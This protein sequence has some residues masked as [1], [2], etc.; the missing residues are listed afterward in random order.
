MP[1]DPLPGND[2]AGVQGAG[3]AESDSAW[4]NFPSSRRACRKNKDKISMEVVPEDFHLPLIIYHN[5]LGF[6]PQLRN[7][8]YSK[9]SL[10]LIMIKSIQ[11][12]LMRFF[13]DTITKLSA[14]KAENNSLPANDKSRICL[15]KKF[16]T[17]S[18][19]R[20]DSALYPVL[21]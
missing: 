8:R 14:L 11:Q 9:L 21:L 15:N 13:G 10:L 1:T 5:V 16:I 3:Q 20:L 2:R 18:L 19:K 17:S 4:R 6:Q 7:S 12:C